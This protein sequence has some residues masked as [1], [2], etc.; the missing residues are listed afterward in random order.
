MNK[1]P[2]ASLRKK[3]CYSSNGV[4]GRGVGSSGSLVEHSGERL[5]RNGQVGSVLASQSHGL[6][7]E[8]DSPSQMDG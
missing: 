1:E 2:S 5:R 8:K 6:G 7:V 3:V 4:G